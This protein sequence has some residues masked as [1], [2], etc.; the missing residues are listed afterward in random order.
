VETY[1]WQ[2]LPDEQRP[3]TDADLVEGLAKELDWTRGE[4]LARGLKEVS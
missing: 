1:T 2:V 4:L 3:R